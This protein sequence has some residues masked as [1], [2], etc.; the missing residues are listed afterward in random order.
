MSTVYN[1]AWRNRADRSIARG[2]AIS[3][4]VLDP[5]PTHL[6]HGKGAFVYCADTGKR[7]ID[8]LSGL[9]TNLFGYGNE[10]IAKAVSQAYLTGSALSLSSSLEVECAELIQLDMPWVKRSVFIQGEKSALRA[11]IEIAEAATGKTPIVFGSGGHPPDEGLHISSL[12]G[13]QKTC[14]ETGTW[15]V[16]DETMTGYR[17][18]R[19]SLSRWAG[20]EPDLICLGGAMGGGMSLSAVCGRD[21][22]GMNRHFYLY[23][24]GDRTA[25]AAFKAVHQ[26]LKRPQWDL[27][28]L[29]ERGK[30][31]IQN[32]NRLL[33]GV[34]SLEGC[35]THARLRGDQNSK[36][37]FLQES[38]KA[39]L[40]FGSEF[41]FGFQHRELTE[42]VLGI[43]KDIAMK[44]KLGGNL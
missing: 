29:Q 18:P 7:Y 37:V 41:Y 25:L 22:K 31:F 43:L 30:L 3:T 28:D 9:G 32:F 4:T 24:A 26:M 23:S 8:F 1:A 27:E 13:L 33:E 11:A 17:W 14:R 21:A 5:F 42:E 39:G 35:P 38:R 2:S 16:M 12:Q 40:L 20:I 19:L 6:S 15:L 10:E 36:V 34:V 44:I